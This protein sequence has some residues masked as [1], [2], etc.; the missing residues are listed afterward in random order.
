MIPAIL[1]RSSIIERLSARIP[2][3]FTKINHGLWG[4]LVALER[5]QS[6]GVVDPDELE[7]ETGQRPASADGG[8]LDEL[9]AALARAPLLGER[10]HFA[11]T[12]Y[13]FPACRRINGTPAQGLDAVMNLMDRYIPRAAINA[14]GLIWKSA[15]YDGWFSEVTSRLADRQVVLVGPSRLRHFGA[16]AG[17][18]DF[19]FC[20]IHPARARDARLDTYEKLRGIY[21]E[22]DDPVFLLSAGH[23]AP[24][25]VIELF[26][27]LP[28]ATFLDMGLTLGLCHISS[29]LKN[30]WA[31]A[32]RADVARTIEAIHPG[33]PDDERAFLA[34]TSPAMRRA[35]WQRFRHGIEPALAD[36]IGVPQRLSDAGE[37]DRADLN[38]GTV[39]FVEP[40]IP[41]WSRIAQICTLSERDHRWANF[42]PVNAALGSVLGSLMEL[43][44]DRS[45][46]PS[47]SATSALQAIAGMHAVRAGR[48]L[49][50][51][52]SAFG[53]FSGAIG[54]FAGRNCIVDCD[55]SGLLDL[56]PLARLDPGSW[57]GLIVT[58]VFGMTADFSRYGAFCQERGKRLIIDSALG[59]PRPRHHGAGADEVIS[60]HHTKPWGFGEGGCAIVARESASL[61]RSF[62]NFGAGTD[63]AFAPYASNG[64]M[65]DVA[66]AAILERLERLPSWSFFYEQQRRR[67][68]NLVAAAGL[69]ML[70][71]CLNEAISPHLPVLAPGP[72][73]LEAM[74]AARFAVRK[75]YRPLA[76]GFPT[77]QV[78]FSRIVNVPCHPAMA[79]TPTHELERFFASLNRGSAG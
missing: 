66:A 23:L 38:A 67:I 64:K 16:F 40:K 4:R 74:P 46:I 73:A 53:F 51:A 72:I 55:K 30:P 77:A 79:A 65:S 14:D 70:G 9:R 60:F 45:V 7:R 25:I 3:S 12:P 36:V 37:L 20:E 34:K 10:F 18:E 78:L 43:P 52:V 24:L 61:V 50:W 42:G 11:A 48:P 22:L 76:P 1:D 21:S 33:W 5:L 75:Y 69:K 54:A 28:R 44:E 49:V 31:L 58:N 62:L 26:A 59:F 41:D 35:L 29:V 63:A 47:S 68:V 32:R 13:A 19:R 39:P 8:F 6:L 17:I 56:E 71:R 2:F 57:D 15:V 27:D